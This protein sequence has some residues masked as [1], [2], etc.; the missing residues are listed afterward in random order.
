LRV[1]I[2]K[3]GLTVEEFLAA[4]GCIAVPQ[5]WSRSE[6]GDQSTSSDQLSNTSFTLAVN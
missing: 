5:R 1:L 3:A 6:H 4:V 2:S